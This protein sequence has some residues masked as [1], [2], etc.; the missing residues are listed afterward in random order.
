MKRIL[1]AIGCFVIVGAIWFIR[2]RPAIDDR[3]SMVELTALVVGNSFKV[4][5]TRFKIDVGR[6]PTTEEGLVALIRCPA[7]CEKKWKG[8]YVEPFD[9]TI[10][11]DAWRSPFQYRSP[12]LHNPQEYDLWSLGPDRTVSDDDIGNWKE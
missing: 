8:P 7:G 6:L 9:G 1:I 10:L 11:L 2:S 4:P 5:I 3:Q 12:G